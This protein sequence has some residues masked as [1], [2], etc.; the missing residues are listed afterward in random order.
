MR[1]VGY[2]AV[3]CAAGRCGLG[4]DGTVAAPLV[5]AVRGAVAAGGH[6]VMVST[7]CL[8]GPVTCRDRPAAPMLVVQPCDADRQPTA[9]AVLVGPLRTS[10]DVDAVGTWLRAGRLDPAF[11]PAHLTE[12]RRHRDPRH[13]A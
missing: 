10:A 2:T 4:D 8:F 7:G 6:G 9:Q 3:V 13:T 12:S 5:E 11:L 1:S